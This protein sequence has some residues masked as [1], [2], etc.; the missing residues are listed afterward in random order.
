MASNINIS[1]LTFCNFVFPDGVAFGDALSGGA[2]R[3]CSL[4][5]TARS[6]Q[7]VVDPPQLV[8]ASSR[9]KC[10]SPQQKQ[11][12]VLRQECNKNVHFT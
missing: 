11:E 5:A 2:A 8:H 1:L 6:T 3:T 7:A 12:V 4:L 10:K 9:H